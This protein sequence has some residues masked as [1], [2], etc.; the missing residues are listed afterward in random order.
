MDKES[1]FDKIKKLQALSERGVGGEATNA[2]SLLNKLLKENGICL[3]DIFG[4]ENKRVAYKIKY[5]SSLEKMLLWQC[6]AHLFGS[7]SEPYNTAFRYRTGKMEIYLNLTKTEYILFNDYFEFHKKQLKEKIKQQE[8]II[9]RAY[10]HNQDI[11]D[12]AE[13]SEE[14]NKDTKSK[15]S[16]SEI[17][18]ILAMSDKMDEDGIENYHK[19][20]E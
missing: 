13:K 11:Y 9:L 3:E 18:S 4:E 17:L 12:I 5:S 1:L 2:K 16:M 8:K 15:M 6:I 20:I 10:I 14:E 19:R 7:D